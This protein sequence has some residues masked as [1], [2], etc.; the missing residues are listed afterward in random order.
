VQG[1]VLRVD[2]ATHLV[3]QTF[4]VV[5]TGQVGGAIWSSPAVDAATNTVYVSTGTPEGGGTP[6]S[7]PF[8]L[9]I[10]A[11]D[12]TTLALRHA[13]QLPAAEIGADSDFGA[14][15]TLFTDSAGHTLVGAASKNGIFYAL[16]RATL[17]ARPVWQ[18]TL[19]TGGYN[20]A[21][22]D[23]SISSA[24]FANGTVYIA[25]GNTTVA[26]HACAGAVRAFDAGAGSL[27]WAQC[28]AGTVMGALAYANGLVVDAAGSALEV[29]RASDG[30]VLFTDTLYHPTDPQFILAGSPTIAGGRIFE[31]AQDGTIYAYGP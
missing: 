25:G 7:Q 24:A 10:L 2:L 30:T 20:P 16:D 28:A 23:G 17:A 19:A 27:R 4:N 1:Q 11:L 8:T 12:A 18:A 9:G 13:W 14:S 15:P 26:G 21:A 31:G 6:T 29:R 22:G 3:A 5:P